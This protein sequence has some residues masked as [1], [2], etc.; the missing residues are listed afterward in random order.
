MLVDVVVPV[1]GNW[2]VTRRC[3]DALAERDA[4]VR[5]IFVVDDAS[6]DDTA[7][8][9]RGRSDV[10]PIILGQNRG[11]A[12]ACNAALAHVRADATLFLNNDTIVPPGAIA[13]LSEELA[14]DPSIGAAGPKLLYA[15]GTI[16]SA[17]CTFTRGAT[18]TWRLYAHLDGDLAQANVP[19]DFPYV[20]GAALLVRTALLRELGGFD[21]RYRNGAEDVDLCMRLRERG[22][23]VR[24]VPEAEIFHIEGASRGKAAD[25]DANWRT[26]VARW[27]REIAALPQIDPR[28]PASLI[29]DFRARTPVERLVRAHI[30]RA[31]RAYAGARVVTAATALAVPIERMRARLENRGCVTLG[32]RT[33]ADVALTPECVQLGFF[34]DVAPAGESERIAVVHG[35]AAPA[36]RLQVL[37]ETLDPARSHFIDYERLDAESLASL[38]RAGTVIFADAGDA[39]GFIGGDRL[40]A[41]AAVI[42]PPDARFLR[43]MPADVAVTYEPHE[44]AAALARVRHDSTEMHA[45]RER[46]RRECLLRAPAIYMGERIRELARARAYGV[47]DPR[48]YAL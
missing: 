15:D 40:A 20:A 22:A 6:P 14:A 28:P 4:C 34:D 38:H 33:A 18:G 37:R 3:L 42:A 9:L 44:L 19:A 23:R 21:E 12:G 16:Q 30:V 17:G 26:F 41:G 11:F 47:P 45:L 1:H 5:E 7:H 39:W 46:A 31:L 43:A 8:E 48:R 25:D 13:R 32:Y 29:L 24:Y 2:E 36:D 27:S 10:T 35:S